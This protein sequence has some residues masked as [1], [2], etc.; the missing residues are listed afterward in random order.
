ML[1]DET[2][3]R[4]SGR[5]GLHRDQHGDQLSTPLSALPPD[6]ARTMIATL[7]PFDAQPEWAQ[8]MHASVGVQGDNTNTRRFV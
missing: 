2:W 5:L 7:G 8:D 4:R 1:P 3:V 6:M